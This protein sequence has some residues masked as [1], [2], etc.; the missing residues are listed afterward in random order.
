MKLHPVDPYHLPNF[1]YF[2]DADYDLD[3]VSPDAGTHSQLPCP[4]CGQ[5]STRHFE[6]GQNV[7]E[8]LDNGIMCDWECHFCT[9]CQG[10]FTDVD[11]I[12]YCNM[13]TLDYYEVI[14]P[15]TAAAFTLKVSPYLRVEALMKMGMSETAMLMLEYSMLIRQ[16]KYFS[17]DAMKEM[18]RD[19]ASHELYLLKQVYLT[20]RKRATDSQ[21]AERFPEVIFND[22]DREYDD[23]EKHLLLIDN[24]IWIAGKAHYLP[25]EHPEPAAI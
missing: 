24:Y 20:L 11:H 15:L 14:N 5:S 4:D 22:L 18:K 8:D 1:I 21:E 2:E 7:G 13:P 9:N 12:E 19:K 23:H 6:R 25:A 16:P 17:R 3:L 10:I